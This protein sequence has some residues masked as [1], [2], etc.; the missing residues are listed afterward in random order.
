MRLFEV[1]FARQLLAQE[2]GN[3]HV[4]F[5]ST[6]L[7]DYH[8][9]VGEYAEAIAIARRRLQADPH[10][11]EAGILL[12][13]AFHAGRLF[14]LA[15]AAYTAVLAECTAPADPRRREI[16]RLMARN[17][18]ISRRF[19]QAV[20][21][22][23][24][25]LAEKPNDIAARLLLV[26]ALTKARQFDPALALA[27]AP[28]DDTN[29]RNAL[30]LA[31]AVGLCP[32]GSGPRSRSGPRVRTAGPRCEFRT[33]DVVYGLYRTA[34]LLGQPSAAQ[35]GREPGPSRLAPPANW[36]TIFAYCASGYCDCTAAALV[37]DQTL[38]GSPQNVLLL[39]MGGEAAKQC[40]CGCRSGICRSCLPVTSPW[41]RHGGSP[42]G[43]L[44]Q[45]AL[46]FRH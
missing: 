26:D 3:P 10:D 28:P 6:V 34:S 20:L 43:R 18:S 14:F 40:G 12:G 8:T 1:D 11:I 29:A 44:V 24:V 23:D 45:S 9:V 32:V 46:S 4:Q 36:A 31:R 22:L 5:Y 17:F 38:Q 13:N 27:H 15:D 42:G 16:R 41:H 19:D 21:E 7:A 35:V 30:A 39:S 33:P 25:L 37:L 2:K